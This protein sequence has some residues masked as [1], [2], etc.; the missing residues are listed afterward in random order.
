MGADKNDDGIQ[1]EGDH[2]DARR[3]RRAEETFVKDG[4]AEQ[5]TREAADALDRPD[6]GEIEAPRQSAEGDVHGPA[7]ARPRSGE[8]PADARLDDRLKETFPASDPVSTSPGSD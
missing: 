5:K 4:L 3:F 8:Q 2:A 6:A 7:K 1:G